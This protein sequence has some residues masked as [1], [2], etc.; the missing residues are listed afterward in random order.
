MKPY[1]VIILIFVS[2]CVYAQEGEK[3]LID[4]LMSFCEAITEEQPDRETVIKTFQALDSSKTIEKSDI[5]TSQYGDTG[6]VGDTHYCLP[7][8][9]GDIQTSWKSSDGITL[10]SYRKDNR[11]Y[12]E[13][14]LAVNCQYEITDGYRKYYNV[15]PKFNISHFDLIKKMGT[16]IMSQ[17]QP[18]E[19]KYCTYKYINPRTKRKIWINAISW[20]MPQDSYNTL[21][22]LRI[23]NMEIEKEGFLMLIRKDGKEDNIF[24][25]GEEITI[26]EFYDNSK[27]RYKLVQVASFGAV[28]E[29]NTDSVRE[30]LNPYTVA[31]S[32]IPEAP[33][34]GAIADKRNGYNIYGICNE[35]VWGV[36]LR[37]YNGKVQ[38]Y[39]IDRW[40]DLSKKVS[41]YT[42]LYEKYTDADILR[43]LKDLAKRYT[44]EAKLPKTWIFNNLGYLTV[45]DLQYTVDIVRKRVSNDSSVNYIYATPYGESV[46]NRNISMSLYSVYN[47]GR[48]PFNQMP[49]TDTAFSLKEYVDAGCI[50]RVYDESEAPVSLETLSGRPPYEAHFYP[51]LNKIYVYK[52]TKMEK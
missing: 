43:F 12:Y 39:P 33:F 17:I 44:G 37:E 42:R 14:Y 50:I 4:R 35:V 6:A 15:A 51:R 32:V 45:K 48:T 28:E 29:I 46:A 8:E 21:Y 20:D 31:L 18:K 16:P 26:P 30:G 13:L 3:P 11:L 40:I 9:V 52:V 38:V 34:A 27:D 47:G 7:W 41:K 49:F 2:A 5:S 23:T 10:S 22:S 19:T 24:K 25:A 36:P 1:I